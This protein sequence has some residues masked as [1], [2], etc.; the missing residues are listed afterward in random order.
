MTDLN[1][2]TERI[3]LAPDVF[4][5]APGLMGSVELLQPNLLGAR[6][7][8]ERAT[9]ALTSALERQQFTTVR[10][11]EI[12]AQPVMGPAAQA[13]RGPDDRPMLTLEVP[14]IGREQPQVVLL[15]DEEGIVT[16]HFALPGTI[17]HTVRFDVPADTVATSTPAR[18]GQERGLVSPTGKKRLSV[19]VFPALEAEVDVAA[20]HLAKNW[21]DSH[22]RP[23]L[24]R[25]AG[26]QD[27]AS[28]TR[29]D[30]EA[31]N[32]L[33]SG[34]ALLFIHGTGSTSHGSFGTLDENTWG[35]LGHHYG[36]RVFAYDH[37]TLSVDPCANAE[38]LATLIPPGIRLEVDIIAHSRGG[39]VSRAIA[40]AGT[41][42]LFPVRVNKIVHVGVPNAGTA[43]ANVE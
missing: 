9:A 38:T 28:V 13:N 7:G 19:L 30:G 24:R 34:P 2:S 3:E 21:E 5:R 25:F 15:A 33:A 43:L 16:W 42:S 36:G 18:G 8:E 14:D 23:G 37:P 4:V 12:N 27:C 1:G 10:S 40:C 41:E 29:L 31:W 17:P 35:T 11:L 39:L 20:W 32:L 26:P 22:R 6:A